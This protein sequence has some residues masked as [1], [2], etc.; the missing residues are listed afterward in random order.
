[1]LDA[2]HPIYSVARALMRS[3]ALSRGGDCH[4]LAQELGDLL[5]GEGRIQPNVVEGADDAI[6][7]AH[8]EEVGVLGAAHAV[9]GR[10]AALITRD[11]ACEVAERGVESRRQD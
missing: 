3:A 9:A 8:E 1:M 2:C 4:G 7:E 5:S 11:E 6:V 10:E